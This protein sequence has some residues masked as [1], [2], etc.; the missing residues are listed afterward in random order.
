MAAA[1][2]KQLN[3]AIEEADIIFFVTDAM[4]GIMAQDIDFS[5]RLRKTSKRIY[6]IVNKVDHK[7]AFAKV[8]DFFEL[9]LGEP[10]PVSALNGTGIERVIDD[11]AKYLAKTT[12][13]EKS[14]SVN[15]AIVGRPNV[16]KSSY[17]NSIFMEERVIVHPVAGTTRDAVDTYLDYKGRDYVLVDTAGIRHNPKIHESADFYG[18]VRSKEAVERS[19]VAVVL[20][21]GFDGLREDDQRIINLIIKEGKGLIIAVNKWDLVKNAEMSEYQDMMIKKMRL[22]MN[23]PVIFISSK[24]RKNVIASLD[25]IWKVYERFK[26]AV[27]PNLLAGLL[28]SLN[29]AAEIRSKRI[30]FLYLM[31]QGIRP[32]AFVLGIKGNR[33]PDDNLKR[34]IDNYF[35]K[36]LDFKGVPIKIDIKTRK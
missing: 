28:K 2:L 25:V 15:V 16:G 21:D 12:T 31:Q 18:N 26:A 4:S 24:T 34:Y 19:D 11:A 10:Y 36:H 32:P 14:E 35:R 8:M 3:R 29:D 23:F 6:L 1:V 33:S 5:S 13:T 22:I 17:L 7:S 27:P 20:L 9:G 30:K